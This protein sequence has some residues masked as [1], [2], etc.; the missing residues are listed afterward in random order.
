ML[1]FGIWSFDKVA[2]ICVVKVV[3]QGKAHRGDPANSIC[4]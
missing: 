4:Q 2:V 1:Y 3:T